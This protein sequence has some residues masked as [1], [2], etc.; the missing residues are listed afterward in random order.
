M[1]YLGRSVRMSTSC[2]NANGLSNECGSPGREDM[3]KSGQGTGFRAHRSRKSF[4]TAD[5]RTR[6]FAWMWPGA[7]LEVWALSVP[8]RN[9]R[10]ASWASAMPEIFCSKRRKKYDKLERRK[11]DVLLLKSTM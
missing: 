1:L 11:L 10:R 2:E 4:A 8:L 3:A 5:G 7:M 9:L 6:R